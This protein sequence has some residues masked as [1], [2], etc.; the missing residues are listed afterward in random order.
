MAAMLCVVAAAIAALAISQ[1]S[2][3]TAAAPW[4]MFHHDAS[5][6]GLSS[7]STANNTLS[8]LW[9]DS[10]GSS[11]LYNSP[12][13]G[14]DGTV[15]ASNS[16]AT[17]YAFNP[18]DGSVKWYDVTGEEFLSSPA[19][20]ADGST[21]YFNGPETDAAG[22]TGGE[23]LYAVSASTGHLKWVYNIDDA[24]QAHDPV[25]GSDG[26]IYFGSE[27]G[28]IYAITDNGTNASAKW[29][30]D[31]AGVISS[32][33]A[34]GSDGT[35]YA[36][37][38]YNQVM[39]AIT[40]AG[41][42]KWY[43]LAGGPI[44]S[45]PS[46]ASDGTIYFGCNDDNV[47]AL[48][49]AGTQANFKWAYTT[50]DWVWASPA[51]ASDGTIYFGSYDGYFY[52]VYPNG[53]L[54]WAGGPLNGSIISSAAI[55]A[56]GEIYFGADDGNFY[57]VNS[58]D[59]HYYYFTIGGSVDGSPA[60]DA[61]GIVYEPAD[62]HGDFYAFGPATSPSPTPTA[63]STPTRT[64]T[65]T[66]TATRTATPATTPTRTPSPTAT[67]SPTATLSPTA[68]ETPSPT[69]TLSP[70][71]TETPTPTR[72]ATATT[73]PTAMATVTPVPAKLSIAPARGSFGNKPLHSPTVKTFKV[74]AAATAK[75]GVSAILLQSFSI[76][77]SSGDYTRDP[78]TTCTEPDSLAPKETCNIVI[79]F[80]PSA[81]TKGL[82]DTGMLTVTTN[83]ETIK[84]VGGVVQLK[85]GGKA[86]K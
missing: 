31:T 63:T 86:P 5:H 67:I 36:G 8:Q 54:K 37:D 9:L 19:I 3:A 75:S 42:L 24:N 73:T 76:G 1:A 82:T 6:T 74:K 66:S 26:T 56:D 59:T 72:T 15:Y 78:A 49:D 48:T 41:A 83:A 16:G 34:I 32:S 4:P 60:I 38:S 43:Y 53:S 13:I 84:P 39:W 68:T 80:T 61:N 62:I 47:Y 22:C 46:I 27:D 20:S 11:F 79:D 25:I 30:Y 21:V 14:P 65:A 71:G 52:A 18:G 55:G 7:Y 51:I 35:V 70:T 45:S 29:I 69:A 12:A 10:T 40:S 77:S 33:P 81:P 50:G 44:Y 85:G 17:I 57:S 23:C 28:G 2:H 58:T 64:A